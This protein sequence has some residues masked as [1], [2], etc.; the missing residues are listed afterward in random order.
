M[1]PCL[2][3]T[4]RFVAA[5]SLL[6]VCLVQSGC[7]EPAEVMAP[8]G[9]WPMYRHDLAG[10]GHSPLRDITVDNVEQLATTWTYG[11][12]REDVDEGPGPNSQA[13]PIVVDGV[14]YL[15]AA[16]RVVALESDNG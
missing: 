9:D 2:L 5:G 4:R 10:T 1:C 13:T 15:P 16:D 8:A 7:A 3:I 6:A 11:L 14:M 12:R